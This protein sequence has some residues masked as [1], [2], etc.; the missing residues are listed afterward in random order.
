MIVLSPEAMVDARRLYE[1]LRPHNP[2]AADRAMAAIWN[3][4]ELVEKM[5]G[6][7]YRTARHSI[8]QFRIQFGKRGYIV[9]YTVRSSDA[10]LIV[11]R[12][13]HGRE[14]RR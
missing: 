1:F 10:A 5:P 6:L 2:D 7:G 3:K 13:W 11:L 4:I 9:R 8:R 12:I 14:A